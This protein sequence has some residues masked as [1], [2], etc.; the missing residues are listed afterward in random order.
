MWHSLRPRLVPAALQ[1]LSRPRRVPRHA[2]AAPSRTLSSSCRCD[3]AVSPDAQC[4][5]ATAPGL[6]LYNTL[7]RQKEAFTPRPDQGNCVSM[8]VCGVTV[9]D[10]SHIGEREGD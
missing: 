9:Y 4:A 6:V 8:Y 2:F 10:Y 3:S 1:S 5:G 7:T